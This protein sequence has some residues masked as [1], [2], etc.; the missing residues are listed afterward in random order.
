MIPPNQSHDN[1]INLLHRSCRAD[2]QES[3]R[4]FLE[5][6]DDE[7]KDQIYKEVTCLSQVETADRLWGKDHALDDL[8]RLS[9]AIENVVKNTLSNLREDLKNLTYGHICQLA[10]IY[11]SDCKWGEHH[12]LDDVG[13]LTS[14]L[15]MAGIFN[16]RV[17]FNELFSKEPQALKYIQD[18]NFALKVLS[19][20]SMA[21]VYLSD[22]LKNDR[23]IALAAISQNWQALQYASAAMQNDKEIILAAVSQNGNALQ[24]ASK[25]LKNDREIVLAA[26]SQNGWALEFASD[27]LRNHREIVLAAVSQNGKAFHFASDALRN[28]IEIVLAAVSQDGSVL[29]FASEA[30]KNSRQIV[31]AAVSQNGNALQCASKALKNDREIVLAAVSQNGNA[32]QYASYELKNDRE[33]VL[34]AVSQDGNALRFASKALKNDR[35]IA[36]AAVSQNGNALQYASYELKNDR[37]FLFTSALHAFYRNKLFFAQVAETG[38]ISDEIKQKVFSAL[39]H[40]H[41]ESL[42]PHP[43]LEHL[44]NELLNY[45]NEELKSFL[46]YT[47]IH[48][49]QKHLDVIFSLDTFT[50]PQKKALILPLLVI[51]S[52]QVDES[53]KTVFIHSL[54]KHYRKVF[55]DY[56]KIP[57]LL[58]LFQSIDAVEA[59]NKYELISHMMQQKDLQSTDLINC[60]HM[61]TALTSFAPEKWISLTREHL[62]PSYLANL[63][64]GDL[65]VHRIIP[66]GDEAIIESAS[67]FLTYR[68]PGAFLSYASQFVADPLI[69]EALL[70]FTTG[71]ISGTFQNDRNEVNSHNRFLTAE[72]KES[73]QTPLEK[74]IAIKGN[75]HTPFLVEEFLHQKLV[76]DSHGGEF[77]KD[78]LPFLRKESTDT[79]SFNELQKNVVHLLSLQ[80]VDLL[81]AFRALSLTLED[82]QYN[83][84][85]FKNDI[86]A[87]IQQLEGTQNFAKTYLVDSDDAEDLL[88]C[89]TEVTGSCQR[90]DGDPSLNKCLMGYA[91]DGKVRLLAVKNTHD[92]IIA[93]AILKILI[94]DQNQP[95]LFFERVYGDPSYKVALEAFAAKKA[96]N[97]RVPL[98]EEGYGHVLR[99]FGNVAPF[100]YE[101]GGVGVS[102]GQYKINGKRKN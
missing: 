3:A 94:N 40:Q 2:D 59:P 42:T 63:L 41:A 72:Q 35:D 83:G 92:T 55:K 47:F 101:D 61:L 7:T 4:L 17:N 13:R 23:D 8:R 49:S 102:N 56:L 51:A 45:K 50:E 12:A 38:L 9:F 16:D 46:I 84:L 93:R 65:Q 11:P 52:L 43:L 73:W 96:H 77:L 95:V 99:S 21:F 66:E 22:E 26:V 30:L 69:C 31:F 90:V 70:R 64:L 88:L 80:Q 97:M 14:A 67:K 100:E 44:K 24:C 53:I 48:T 79:S 62:T 71:V 29:R 39:V 6:T 5:N 78:I 91:L 85:E 81:I 1:T 36:L 74:E 86:R 27:A 57:I 68:M 89:G 33:I 87:A 19:I 58:K 82:P 76:V 15:H 10:N 98:F 75:T 20:N 28:H 34:A 54:N 37:E 60:M 25:A 32:L 18:K